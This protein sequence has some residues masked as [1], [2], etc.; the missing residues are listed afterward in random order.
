[1]VK[2]HVQDVVAMDVLVVPT[3][4]FWVLFVLVLL[5]QER[6]RVLHC[7]ITAHSTAQWTAPQGVAMVP[8][9]EAPRYLWRDRDRLSGTACRQRVQYRG[10]EEVVMARRI[11]WQHPSGER[12][13]GSIR[14]ACLEQVILRHE[15]HLQ[16]L[17]T[18]SCASYH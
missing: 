14:R 9:D 10:S 6:W 15:R 1:L 13:M 4:T 12:R 2:H 8:W 11:P 18:S 5:A 16:R 3:V 17:L 7:T